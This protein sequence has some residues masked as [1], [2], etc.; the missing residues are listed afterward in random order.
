MG[1]LVKDLKD[2]ESNG[3]VLPDGQV[4]QGILHAIAGDNLGSHGIGGFLK[5]FS[6]SVYFCRYCEMDQNTF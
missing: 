2:L 3:V 4:R 5:N 6:L 1:Q